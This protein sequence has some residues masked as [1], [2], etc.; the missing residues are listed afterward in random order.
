MHEI[1]KGWT[2]WGMKIKNLSRVSIS[3]FFFSTMFFRFLDQKKK[4]NP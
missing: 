1:Q 2:M 4:K 3:V